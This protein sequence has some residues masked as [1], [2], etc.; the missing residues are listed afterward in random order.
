MRGV[1]RW[2]WAEAKRR[3][4]EFWLAGVLFTV[5]TLIAGVLLAQG[6]P[7]TP[8]AWDKIRVGLEAAGFGVG[9]VIVLSL[10]LAL[11]IA[12]YQQR[13]ALRATVLASSAPTIETTV[14]WLRTTLVAIGRNPKGDLT[15]TPMAEL[16]LIVGHWLAAWKSAGDI[17]IYV[18]IEFR[19]S[20]P[21][22]TWTIDSTEF[23]HQ[24]AFRG[25]METGF[26]QAKEKRRIPDMSIY[27]GATATQK[28]EYEEVDASYDQY[29]W[30]DLGRRAV[31]SLQSTG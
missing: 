5:V 3:R 12:P 23:L 27:T 7:S 25:I 14:D 20:H 15:E 31:L 19:K 9:A 24:A 18:M 16:C 30:T 2:A 26:V 8:T 11:A 1:L 10:G 21:E 4:T 6:L 17:G 22:V 29:R 13:N 28:P